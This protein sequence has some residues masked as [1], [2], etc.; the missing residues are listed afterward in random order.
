MIRLK[1]HVKVYSPGLRGQD[2]ENPG[3]IQ[4]LYIVEDPENMT[5]AQLSC[6]IA[7]QW[8]IL[9]P[10][11]PELNIKKI[12]DDL[13][14]AVNLC[15][16]TSV[17]ET[18][19]D[20]GKAAVDPSDQR[21]VARVLQNPG[22]PWPSRCASV[23]Q[24]WSPQSYKGVP[25]KPMKTKPPVPLF[26]LPV[27]HGEA[28]ARNGV[29]RAGA[30]SPPN[31]DHPIPS[32]ERDA[33]EHRTVLVEDSQKGKAVSKR[34]RPVVPNDGFDAEPSASSR[35]NRKA[36]RDTLGDAII[37][38]INI[39]EEARRRADQ[40]ARSPGQ[41]G[42]TIPCLFEKQ[43]A[44]NPTSGKKRLVDSDDVFSIPSSS[45]ESQEGSKTQPPKRGKLSRTETYV[46]E[47]NMKAV[48]AASK[49]QAS[50]G[51][52]IAVDPELCGMATQDDDEVMIV[53]APALRRGTRRS[54]IRGPAR[55]SMNIQQNLAAL[56]KGAP[57]AVVD[58]DVEILSQ[59]PA[60]TS[61]AKKTPTPRKSN[62]I[63]A[64]ES[65]ASSS[66]TPTI[67]SRASKQPPK[68][69]ASAGKR[70]AATT[71]NEPRSNTSVT[72][73]S[74][75][76]PKLRE[77]KPGP[78][79]VQ[80]G[81]GFAQSPAK[82]KQ[83]DD[84]GN[85]ATP[86]TGAS[87]TMFPRT[88]SRSQTNRGSLQV[89]EKHTPAASAAA[90]PAPL[91]PSQKSSPN[92][93][94]NQT[95][96][97]LAEILEAA[98]KSA[99]TLPNGQL[100]MGNTLYPPGTT[101]GDVKMI[102]TENHLN[103]KISA[104]MEQRRD[105]EYV[106]C[107]RKILDA[108]KELYMAKKGGS[109]TGKIK[110]ARKKLTKTRNELNEYPEPKGNEDNN[111]KTHKVDGAV[112]SSAT[113]PDGNGPKDGESGPSFSLKKTTLSQDIPFKANPGTEIRYSS[114]S[115]GSSNKGKHLQQKKL[116]FSKAGSKRKRPNLP[117][118]SEESESEAE[119]S[120]SETAAKK[121]KHNTAKNQPVDKGKG[122]AITE[123]DSDSDSS[124]S[125]E[126][127]PMPRCDHRK[128]TA[129][130]PQTHRRPSTYIPTFAATA[131]N[132]RRNKNHWS[133]D[134]ASANEFGMQ[135]S[136]TYRFGVDGSSADAFPFPVFSSLGQC[137]D[138]YSPA[139]GNAR[140]MFKTFRG[141]VTAKNR[142]EYGRLCDPHSGMDYELLKRAGAYVTRRV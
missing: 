74:P 77:P 108:E 19:L 61:F 119:S 4:F 78:G 50:K 80:I 88:R 70:K 128:S 111:A 120:E 96:I 118:V 3:P 59:A 64:G 94:S 27:T 2:D 66:K 73:V 109:S 13:F 28:S 54:S 32:T 127:E 136:P 90:T 44:M 65:K 16:S 139:T 36:T 10:T 29:P 100:K 24:E 71:P 115:S 49:G 103:G 67:S 20:V 1:L 15:V 98:S 101:L 11:Y 92:A 39:M 72:K 25:S 130:I 53:D 97:S 60:A 69:S 47:R 86:K 41:T 126:S 113:P 135:S 17:A 85:E 33:E 132:I 43:N 121:Q 99:H 114:T 68:P 18:F 12:V 123:S 48:L 31:G 62:P 51:N 116:D 7:E 40:H 26:N 89:P 110:R 63:P 117:E 105:V 76:K 5:L 134:G 124:D 82:F 52:P 34:K 58:S 75:N 138:P 83:D 104:A 140:P 6:L 142:G 45:R 112:R 8:K 9:M 21:A 22:T 107:L 79:P 93:G 23:V 81:L 87:S 137:P 38:K 84:K 122:R 106:L 55:A 35:L 131:A 37:D 133:G 14:P 57:V 42:S 129:A 141:M 46:M 56:A 95:L 91:R 102:L 125:D 30:V